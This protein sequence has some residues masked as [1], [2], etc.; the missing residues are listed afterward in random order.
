MLVEE[1]GVLAVPTLSPPAIVVPSVIHSTIDNNTL[2][3]VYLLANTAVLN[4][5]GTLYYRADFSNVYYREPGEQRAPLTLESVTF[6]ASVDTTPINLVAVTPT[7]GV[8]AGQIQTVASA[9]ISDATTLGRQLLTAPDAATARTD[10]GA[11]NKPTGGIPATDLTSAVQTELGLA[12]TALQSIAAGTD[13]TV[14]SNTVALSSAAQTALGLANTALQTSAVVNNTDGTLS[15]NSVNTLEPLSTVSI[16]TTSTAPVIGQITYYNATSGNLTP[17]LPALSGLRVGARLAVRRDPDD[18]SANTVTLS[19]AGS[20]IFYSSGG[21]STT[22]P[23]SG[24]QRE[25]QVISVAGTK[26]WSPAGSLNPVAANDQRYLAPIDA[27][28]GANKMVS[29]GDTGYGSSQFGAVPTSTVGTSEFLFT[30]GIAATSVAPLFTHFYTATATFLDTDATGP[31]SFNAAVRVV[32]STNPNTVVNTVYRVT[33]GGRT[34]ATLDP[35]GRIIADPVGITVAAGDVVAVRTFLASGTA[36]PVRLMSFGAYG[37]YGGWTATTDLTAPGSAAVAGSNGQ[38]LY[39]PAALMGSVNDRNAKSVL[40]IGDSAASAYGDSTLQYR[41][42]LN[43]GGWGIRAVTG[44]GGLLNLAL[45]GDR[46]TTFQSTNGSFRRLPYATRANIAIIEYVSNDI[47]ILSLNAIA[48]EPLNVLIATAVRRHGISRVYLTTNTPFTSS[49]DGWATTVNQTLMS[50]APQR[51]IYNTW[52]RAGAPIDP[53]TLLP[54]AVGTSNALVA[55]NFGHPITGIIDIAAPVESS[56]GSGL[57]APPSRMATA[58]ITSGTTIITSSDAAFNSAVIESGGDKGIA[59]TLPGAGA[60]GGLMAGFLYSITN[61]TTALATL[62]AGTTVSSVPIALNTM[63]G[64][65]T[66]PSPRG[67][68][69]IAATVDVTKL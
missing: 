2:V 61:S 22:L 11:Y 34:A 67:H 3:P 37:S 36:Y 55:G 53:T 7:A 25:Y 23:M 32:S 5:T 65:G 4:L 64:D 26:Y 52:V 27:L 68:S 51:A 50:S 43:Q 35:G 57:W 20:D 40:M 33:F 66:H 48:V 30:V 62:N 6:A 9:N 41:P 16:V 12:A 47:N 46:A 69:A 17:P 54:V 21:T 45:P 14:T 39:G 58:S 19:C 60:S 28:S 59:F 31:I 8:L 24:E 44:K 18:I 49:T 15:V 13:I 10:L 42:A 63:T 38:Y 29:I 1:S 56:L